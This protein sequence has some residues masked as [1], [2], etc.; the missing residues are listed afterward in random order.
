MTAIP[1]LVPGSASILDKVGNYL[2]G[3][4]AEYGTSLLAHLT[5][6]RLLRH[7]AEADKVIERIKP[8]LTD[9]ADERIREELRA[10]FASIGM[11][12]EEIFSQ[13]LAMLWRRR[14]VTVARFTEAQYLSLLRF[15]SET[16][17]RPVRTRMRAGHVLETNQ[18]IRVEKLAHLAALDT[19]DDRIAFLGAAGYL[20]P[21][22]ADKLLKGYQRYDRAC[23][24]ANRQLD[25]EYT[26]IRNDI[27]TNSGRPP[28][29]VTDVVR[30][31]RRFFNLLNM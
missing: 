4:F 27:R 26:Q 10:H 9:G 17:P 3:L 31:R 11:A 19:R 16:I 18:H 15:F 23:R 8:H 12:D 25:R 22:L 5:G 13:D 29:G 7:R 2:L 28:I 14:E 24:M 6:D 20:D 1:D 21:T 30:P